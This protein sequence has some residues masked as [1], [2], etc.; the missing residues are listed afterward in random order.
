[1][2]GAQSFMSYRDH[3]PP[4]VCRRERGDR[5]YL[6]CDE[7]ER[8][9]VPVVVTFNVV[10]AGSEDNYDGEHSVC[11]TCLEKALAMLSDPVLI[12][13]KTVAS[14]KEDLA[15]AFATQ[16][17]AD[18]KYDSGTEPYVVHLAEVRDVLVE[19]GWQANAPSYELDLL[20]S[21]WLHDVLEDTDISFSE[22]HEKFGLKVADLVWAVTGVGGSRKARNEDAYEKMRSLPVAIPLK[23]A[24][25]IANAR[26][27]KQ[28]SPNKLYA[29]YRSEY[30]DFY[31]RLW[32][33]TNPDDRSSR[34]WV[35]LD[36]LLGGSDSK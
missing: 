25:R 16:V 35:A 7:C 28:T 14:P 8:T 13:T 27:S 11:R 1:M 19:F 12:R 5:S 32:P 17:H 2:A 36:L 31:G 29:M 26:A 9:D 33:S 22:I 15:R 21:A 20:V 10:A 18:Q 34:M 24:D 30:V 23:L 3:A 6:R 4:T